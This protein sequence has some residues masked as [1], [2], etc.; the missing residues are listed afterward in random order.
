MRAEPAIFLNQPPKCET[1]APATSA[2]MAVGRD[3]SDYVGGARG[4]VIAPSFPGS[5]VPAPRVIVVAV[6][7]C[8]SVEGARPP[9]ANGRPVAVAL[10]RSQ[11]CAGGEGAAITAQFVGVGRDGGAEHTVIKT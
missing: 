1:L 8:S 7:P 9:S 11:C 2:G 4:P 5:Q 6:G 3:D 10:G